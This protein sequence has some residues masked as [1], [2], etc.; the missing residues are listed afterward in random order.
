MAIQD[1]K[2]TYF[3]LIENSIGSKLW[4]NN[5]FFINNS[6]K[7]K[8]ILENGNLSCAY[9]V[10]SI[11]YLLKLIKDLHT[12]VEGTI[13]DLKDSGWY[14]IE[15]PKKGA[16]VIWEKGKHG[17]KHIGF[18]LS[19]NKVISNSSKKGYPILHP[20]DYFIGDGKRKVECFY[21]HDKLK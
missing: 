18:Y 9:Y 1:I 3:K 13:R 2:K 14:K 17:H 20:I 7:S 19:K 10:S 16:I 8:D 6:K 21:F 11:L 15:K 5:Y 12:T 4:R